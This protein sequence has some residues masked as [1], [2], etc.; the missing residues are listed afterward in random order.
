MTML[1]LREEIVCAVVLL[2]III[3]TVVYK[4]KSS[5]M[6][7]LRVLYAAFLHVLLDR[8]YGK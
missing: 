6:Y 2:F 1:I 3:C 8:Y 5:D 7:F 4:I